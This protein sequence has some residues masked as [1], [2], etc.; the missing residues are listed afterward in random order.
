MGEFMKTSDVFIADLYTSKNFR[1]NKRS[2]GPS[3]VGE[4]IYEPHLERTNV[5][6]IKMGTSYVIAAEITNFIKLLTLKL[7]AFKLGFVADEGLTLINDESV[8]CAPNAMFLR[9]I[10]PLDTQFET[11]SLKQLK[12]TQEQ[13]DKAEMGYE[14]AYYKATGKL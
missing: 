11:V 6:V 2:T 1:S 7:Q 14:Y 8:A 12:F 9:D 10:R 13:F 5:I 3:V 4:Y